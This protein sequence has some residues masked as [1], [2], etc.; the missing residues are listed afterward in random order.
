M[1]IFLQLFKMSLLQMGNTDLEKYSISI[2]SAF[3]FKKTPHYNFKPLASLTFPFYSCLSDKNGSGH[4]FS[5]DHK[6]GLRDVN[7]PTL[8]KR[9]CSHINSL[10]HH[11]TVGRAFNSS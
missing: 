11:W 4:I 9:L 2:F 7:L 3:K 1:R 8:A 6:L 5:L 10:K